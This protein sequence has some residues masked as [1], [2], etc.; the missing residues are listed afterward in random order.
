MTFPVTCSL[1][2][3]LIQHHGLF[4][5]CALPSHSL[6]GIRQIVHNFAMTVLIFFVFSMLICACNANVEHLP[7]QSSLLLQ[8]KDGFVF[9][10]NKLKSWR[11]HSNCCNW[12][13]VTCDS[14]TGQVMVLDLSMRNI[15]GTIGPSLFYLTSLH[16]LDFSSNQFDM[17]PIP[18]GFERLINLA[19]LNLS[20]AGFSG[21]IPIGIAPL[22][23]L[24]SL[25]LSTRCHDV[26]P[27]RSLW[28]KK[29]NLR[30]L[31]GKLRNLKELYLDCVS[32]SHGNDWYRML[33]PSMPQLQVLS[34]KNCN[35]SGSTNICPPASNTYKLDFNQNHLF[36]FPITVIQRAELNP[37][38]F[39]ECRNFA[40][41]PI[42]VE[43]FDRPRLIE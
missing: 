36:H 31:V 10:S 17:V 7:D 30:V 19:R 9:P 35:L 2:F 6:L 38:H 1:L 27:A 3:L 32:I 26:R 21:Q 42:S 20:K 33:S 29:P 12:E 14:E 40:R 24:V 43:E 25:D 5:T 39:M 34:L 18:S 16:S 4:L 15:S 28:L 8:L 23:G 11:P 22:T 37:L 41:G 13:G